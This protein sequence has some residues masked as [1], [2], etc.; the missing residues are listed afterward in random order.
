[1][2][3]TVTKDPE[4]DLTI[5]K[6][7]PPVTADEMAAAIDAFWSSD[8]ITKNV[9]WTGER[10]ASI[11]HMTRDDLQKIAGVYKRHA[12]RLH[13]RQGG[14]TAVV[15]PSDIDYG[16]SRVTEALHTSGRP[17]PPYEFTVF[18]TE[19]AALAWIEGE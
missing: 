9:L 4:R 15:A 18:R 17:A 11:A 8:D 7:T 2:P 16:L 10:G 5:F 14:K 19:Q 1:M 3:V 13:L 6:T 12:D